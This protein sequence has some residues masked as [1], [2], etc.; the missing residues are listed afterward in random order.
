MAYGCNIVFHTGKAHHCRMDYGIDPNIP[1]KVLIETLGLQPC[2]TE[3]KGGFEF[4]NQDSRASLMYFGPLGDNVA[5]SY[6]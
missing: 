2:A 6:I 3:K 1:S 5:F 4:W